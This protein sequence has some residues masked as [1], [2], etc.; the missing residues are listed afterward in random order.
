MTT[1]VAIEGRVEADADLA[2]LVAAARAGDRASLEALLES[3]ERR[4]YGFAWRLTGNRAAAE[5]VTQEALLKVCRRLEQYRGGSFAGWVYRIVVRQA[6]D[7]RRAAG[8][9]AEALGE[10][11]VAGVDA[12]RQEQWRR[13]EGALAVLTEKE[14]RALVL[15]E[16][17]GFTSV[18]AARILGCL[19]VTVR[20][21]AAQ[22][23]RKL[24]RALSRCYPE[25]RE[26][27]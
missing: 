6:H 11:A 1:A 14:R 16:M 4:V 19:A 27:L 7:H 24:R 5:D 17:E 18:E 21:R 25:L 2:E 13:V 20:V 22:A 12:V 26:G 23:R 8:P 10:I 9:V 3:I 15:T